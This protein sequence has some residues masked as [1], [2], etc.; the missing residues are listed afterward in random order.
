MIS[1]QNFLKFRVRARGSFE[2]LE[3]E[4]HRWSDEVKDRKY[5]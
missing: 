5:M 3:F 4:I 2:S 1:K